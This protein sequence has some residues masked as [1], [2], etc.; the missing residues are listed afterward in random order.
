MIRILFII[1]YKGR[2]DV[3][4]EVL[5]EQA[6]KNHISWEIVETEVG[7][8]MV[9]SEEQ[10]D[11]VVSR[12]YTA[13]TI[14]TPLPTVELSV[15][16]FDM[17]RAVEECQERYHCRRIG[18]IGT[19][20]MVYGADSVNDLKKDVE[21][22][23]CTLEEERDLEAA[24]L[25]MKGEGC[26][27]FI[28][29]RSL[30]KKAEKMG[31]PAVILG[32]GREAVSKCVGEAIRAVQIRR[33]EQEKSARIQT[34]MDYAFEGILSTDESGIIIMAN[35]Y[36]HSVLGKGDESLV[37]KPIENFFPYE[38]KERALR[39][40]SRLLSKI[41]HLEKMT[42]SLNWIPLETSRQITGSVL[43]FQDITEIQKEEETIRKQLHQ[44][45]FVV[46]YRFEHIVGESRRM[47]DAVGK[48]KKYA[49]SDSNLF[50]Y[51]ETGTGKELF[52]QSVHN[53][54]RRKSG[55]FIA[56]NCAALPEHLLESELFGYV[57]GAFTGAAK[58]GKKGMF[59]LAHNGTIFLD[60]IG[61]LPLKLQ[62]RLLRVIQEK[63]IM[64]LGHD[65]VIP[66]NV[67]VIS[68]SNKELYEAVSRGR[69]RED[70]LYRLNVL[71][72]N[73][74]PLR[75][76][77]EDSWL[78]AQYYIDKLSKKGEGALT[79]IDERAKPW[80]LDYNWPGNVRELRNFCERLTV[81]CGKERAGVEDVQAALYGDRAG[82]FP[83]T[84][85][86]P[87]KVELESEKD[88]ILKA[89]EECHYSRKKAAARLG[90]DVSTLYRRMK[91]Y[92]ISQ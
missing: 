18:V 34:I 83:G 89:L 59:E 85:E 6:Y 22:V 19:F 2:R 68:A 69:F 20:N 14:Q 37:G 12:G 44:K 57:E 62:A 90:I 53:A 64:R 74:P 36:A 47:Q 73:V 61:D 21:V 79:G 66:V 15:T 46:K 91:R 58:G 49:N 16:G 39:E 55:P 88:N 77:G 48:A 75:S 13:A 54:S 4:Q 87:K 65:R 52:A 78:L 17:I 3:V 84:E 9:V 81:F 67:R 8:R 7:E 72:L 5:A 27:A 24:I 40:G 42:V 43:T 60:E 38:F 71:C 30:Y 33:I 41:C 80:I 51:G 25:K 28:G 92:G 45:G 82:V 23:C 35:Q 26:Q 29:G 32:F 10:A 70:L 1:P 86:S 31:A 11:A 76:R 63:E 50:I 56:L